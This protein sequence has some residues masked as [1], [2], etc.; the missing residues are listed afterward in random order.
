MNN[1]Q[2]IRLPFWETIKR[3]FI[4]SFTNFDTIIKISSVWFLLLIVEASL[5]FPYLCTISSEGCVGTGG[6]KISLM[7]MTLA[8]FPVSVAFC[9]RTILRQEF[10][11]FYISFGARELK[12]IGYTI[13]LILAIILPSVAAIFATALLMKGL[14]IPTYSYYFL[15]LYF[16]IF[17]IYTSRLTLALPAIAVNNNNVSFKESYALT[18]GNANRIFWSTAVLAIPGYLCLYI[19]ALLVSF[20]GDT[21]DTFAAKLILTFL[22]YVISF[23]DI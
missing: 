20:L 8:V 11:M 16:I 5:G 15:L 1:E 21:M 18:K 23:I 22:V 19:V 7:L 10:N 14:D 4:Y 17:A 2:V 13:L 3:S 6:Q 9:R 12:Y